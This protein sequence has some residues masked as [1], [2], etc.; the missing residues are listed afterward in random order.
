[1]KSY[2]EIAQSVLKKSEERMAEKK[3]SGLSFNKKVAIA[4]T[5]CAACL[6]GIGFWKLDSVKNA[7]D[8]TKLPQIIDTP[9]EVTAVTTS[10]VQTTVTAVVSADSQTTQITLTTASSPESV[11]VTTKTV[12]QTNPPQTITEGSATKKTY[13]TTAKHTTAPPVTVTSSP[14]SVAVTTKTVSQTNPPQTVTEGSATTKTYTTTAKH[15]TAPPVATTAKRTVT[16]AKLTTTTAKRTTAVVPETT[17][18]THLTTMPIPV[19]TTVLPTEVITPVASETN[20]LNLICDVTETTVNQYF[21]RIYINDDPDIV[22]V[23]DY[24]SDIIEYDFTACMNVM[25]AD[26]QHPVNYTF[27]ELYIRNSSAI[28]IRYTDDGPFYYY[29]RET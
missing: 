11:A 23:L 3:R 29:R 6:C 17:S 8:K 18:N 15:T 2:E 26:S 16:T 13:T 24:Q 19:S 10:A 22:Y 28:C 1:M 12:S 7:M 25:S 20:R 14:E 4:S 21:N 9:H 5:L 27:G